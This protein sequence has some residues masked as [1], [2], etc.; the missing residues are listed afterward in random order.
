MLK[1]ERE[2]HF[3]KG[4]ITKEKLLTIANSLKNNQYGQ[5]LKKL[6]EE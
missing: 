5:Y 6:L 1:N 2:M 3:E 4:Y